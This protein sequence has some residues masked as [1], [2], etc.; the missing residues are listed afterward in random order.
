MELKRQ[1]ERFE[2][3]KKSYQELVDEITPFLKQRKIKFYPSAGK[4]RPTSSL[5]Q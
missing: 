3:A 5:Y 1:K 2:E 4:W